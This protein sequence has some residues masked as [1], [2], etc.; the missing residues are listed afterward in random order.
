MVAFINSILAGVGVGLLAG[1]LSH[2]H[3]TLLAC[4]AGGAAAIA[5]MALFLAYQSWRYRIA[6]PAEG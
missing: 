2:R 6:E 1:D 3:G 4:L 5:L